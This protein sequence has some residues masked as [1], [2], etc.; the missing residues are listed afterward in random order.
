MQYAQLC[1][2][3]LTRIRKK[4]IMI[5]FVLYLTKYEIN[6]KLYSLKKWRCRE[7][8]NERLN[9]TFYILHIIL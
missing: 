1:Y 8:L 3:Y 6:Y 4:L 9:K 2:R 5:D 7:L